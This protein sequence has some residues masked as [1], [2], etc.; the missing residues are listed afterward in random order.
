MKGSGWVGLEEVAPRCKRAVAQRAAWALSVEAMRLQIWGFGVAVVA[1]F[2]ENGGGGRWAL[3]V[4]YLA[5]SASQVTPFIAARTSVPPRGDSPAD[6][7]TAHGE[8]DQ[9]RRPPLPA[10]ATTPIGVK[11]CRAAANTDALVH[12]QA[13]GTGLTDKAI[14][15]AGGGGIGGGALPAYSGRRRSV[16]SPVAGRERIERGEEEEDEGSPTCGAHAREMTLQDFTDHADDELMTVPAALPLPKQDAGCRAAAW[17]G[18][19]QR[20]CRGGGRSCLAERVEVVGRVMGSGEV[21]ATAA[22]AATAEDSGGL[23]IDGQSLAGRRRIWWRWSRRQRR[24]S[25]G[26]WAEDI[27]SGGGGCGP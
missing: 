4:I 1:G 19:G 8:K 21:S 5:D 24:P 11:P 13:V 14:P 17:K 7:M 6:S 27:L 12:S 22:T 9:Q 25:L 18:G 20:R 16:L 26:V 10:S 15:D 3:V 23:S 2:R